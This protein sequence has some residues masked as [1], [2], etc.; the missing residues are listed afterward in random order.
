MPCIRIRPR[1]RL[2]A[3]GQG[4]RWRLPM[5]AI[6][7]SLLLTGCVVRIAY[8]QLEW[9]TRWS[10][11]GYLDLDDS[12]ERMVREIIGR[13]LAWHRTTE[14]P[15]YAAYMR[16]LRAGLS[17]QVSAEFM[18]RQ[19]AT[20]LVIWDRTLLQISPDIAQLLLTLSDEQVSEFFAEIEERNAELAEEYSGYR[21]EERRKK[22]DRSIV[23]AFRWFTGALSRDQ[24][25]LVKS[26][27]AGMHDLTEQWLQRRRAW[28]A[29]FRELMENRADNVAFERQLTDLLL[30]PNQFDSTEYRRLVAANREIAFAMSADVLS[31]L[32]PKQKK[33]LDERLSSLA[34]DFDVLAS[35][36]AR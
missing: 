16:E 8:N 19:Y 31:S 34:E 29:A 33:H 18:A 12:Q 24:E 35:T 15:Q 7:A 11:S 5:L 17:G 25:V 9:L 32:S 13:N 10:V 2:V 28:Q 36:P 14:L 6:L 21:P 3:G 26:Y 20:T 27:T 23:R 22:Q 30:D 1:A 4:F